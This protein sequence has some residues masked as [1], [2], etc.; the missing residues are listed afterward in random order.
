MTVVGTVAENDYDAEGVVLLTLQNND[1]S[2]SIF[3][4][5]QQLHLQ[6]EACW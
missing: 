1:I 6:Q 5:Q 4:L 2:G 3:Q